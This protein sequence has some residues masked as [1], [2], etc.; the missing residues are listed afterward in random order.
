M[1]PLPT[2]V[3]LTKGIGT[4]RHRLTSF[5]LA[6]READIEQ[7]NLVSISSILP[8]LCRLIERVVAREPYIAPVKAENGHYGA[9]KL[10]DDCD[11][12]E[13]AAKKKEVF[14][15]D[16]KISVIKTLYFDS[17]TLKRR[18]RAM[19]QLGQPRRFRTAPKESGSPPI[20]D[21]RRRDRLD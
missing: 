8:P 20:T 1:F 6:L 4:H 12:T 3:F 16:A 5:E 17:M 2:S 9:R 13:G 18:G 10:Q 19:S 15:Q 7:Q 11:T 21:I 14:H